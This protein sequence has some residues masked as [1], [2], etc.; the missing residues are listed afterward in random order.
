VASTAKGRDH[1][2]C[3]GLGPNGGKGQRWLPCSP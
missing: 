3:V 2:G 1:N